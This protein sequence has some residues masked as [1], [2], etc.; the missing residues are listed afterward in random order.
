MHT[1]RLLIAMLL[2]IAAGTATSP[3]LADD[4]SPALYT[5]VV[6]A[7]PITLRDGKFGPFAALQQRIKDLLMPVDPALSNALVPDGQFGARSGKALRRLMDLPDYAQFRPADGQPIR[8]TTGLWQKLFPGSPIPSREQRTMT[9]ILT[10]E[11]TEFDKPA[12]WNFCQNPLPGPDKKKEARR[13]IC[14]TNDDSILTWGPRGATMTGGSEIQTVLLA[15]QKSAPGLLLSTFGT[16]LPSVQRALAL[17][18]VPPA[19]PKKGK[20]RTLNQVSDLELFMCSIW[21]DPVRAANLSLAFAHLGSAQEA[22]SVYDGVYAS[23][24]FDGGKVRAFYGLY[25]ALG[26]TPSEI[27]HAFFLDRATHTSGVTSG[28]QGIDSNTAGA[29]KERADQMAII[30]GSPPYA[31]WKVRRAISSLIVPGRQRDDRNGRD[32][33][34]FVD[35]AGQDGLTAT[36]RTNWLHRSGLAAS[37]VGLSDE[38]PMPLPY[39][40]DSTSWTTRLVPP[41][42]LTAS[43]RASHCPR[44]VIERQ[45]L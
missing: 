5:Y 40:P 20:V 39:T 7:N 43:E 29:I 38:R 11:A 41:Q 14:R 10:Y 32:V 36:E 17:S 19:E 26:L 22:R 24:E 16:E 42:S 1:G 6:R 45:A 9:L 25:K 21:L 13:P 34:F 44:W 15:I 30:L 3:A 12:A 27:D 31:N 37:M 18:K 2:S 35:A 4:S 8:I 33:A 28:V 23:A